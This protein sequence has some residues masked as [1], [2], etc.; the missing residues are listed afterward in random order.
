[1]SNKTSYPRLSVSKT[2]VCPQRDGLLENTLEMWAGKLAEF[3]NLVSIGYIH[4][5]ITKLPQH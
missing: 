2:R 4:H 3:S 5:K 1:M